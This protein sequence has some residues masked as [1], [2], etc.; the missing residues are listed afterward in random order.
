MKKNSSEKN[1]SNVSI[2][3]NPYCII[4][5]NAEKRTVGREG[6][7]FEIYFCIQRYPRVKK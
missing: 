6:D 5:E 7:L 2:S 3:K 4:L 1:R